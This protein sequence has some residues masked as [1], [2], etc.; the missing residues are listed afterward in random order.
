MQ[1]SKY[2]NPLPM[3]TAKL[4]CQETNSM[5]FSN[6][7]YI[8]SNLMKNTIS[9]CSTLSRSNNLEEILFTEELQT[10][11]YHCYCDKGTQYRKVASIP[12]TCRRLQQA[13]GISLPN[14]HRQCAMIATVTLWTATR[15][16][17]RYLLLRYITIFNKLGIYLLRVI[18]HKAISDGKMRKTL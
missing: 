3:I 11:C 12:G 7:S 9:Y 2:Q 18:S 17:K 1:A 13:L 14:S 5:N 6:W 4:L 8:L 10:A 16:C 15:Y